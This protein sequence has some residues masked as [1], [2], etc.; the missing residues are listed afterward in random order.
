MNQG[1]IT[2]IIA[3]AAVLIFFIVNQFVPGAPA[4]LIFIVAGLAIVVNTA[5]HNKDKDK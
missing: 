4:W 2:A 5:M 1:S 3:I